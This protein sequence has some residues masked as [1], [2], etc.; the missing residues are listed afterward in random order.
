MKTNEEKLNDE[1]LLPLK[2]RAG[3]RLKRNPSNVSLAN[4]FSSFF[5]IGLIGFGGG[6]AVIAQ[7]RALAVTKKK[8]LTEKEF[9]EGFALAQSL[10]GTNAGNAAT[11]I[12]YRLKGIAGATAAMVGFILPST[13]M[14]IGLAIFYNSFRQLPYADH[15]FQG[16]NAAVTALILITAYR[17][18]QNVLLKRWQ[19]WVATAAALAVIFLQATVIE[20]ILTAGLIGIF[21]NSRLEKRFKRIET[22]RR[23]A[24]ER[25]KLSKKIGKVEGEIEN[26][27]EIEDKKLKGF[28]HRAL[29]IPL[30]AIPFL[31]Q[32]G[33]LFTMAT[34]FLR[35]GAVTF[36]G[37]FVMVPLIESEVVN[38]YHWLSYQEFVDATALGQVT[39]GPVLITATFVGYR[40]AGLVGA[41][42][43][44]ITIFLPAFLLTV[45]ASS[46]LR[47]FHSNQTV[48][49]FL[50]GVTPAVVGLL[51]AAAWGIGKSGIHS[52]VGLV[53]ALV[54]F[55]VLFRF[56]LNAVWI[57]LGAGLIRFIIFLMAG[58]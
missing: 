1:S 48:Q 31:L 35:I 27:I 52:W 18:G 33:L 29:V 45:I 13:L 24:A 42:V 37:G 5:I 40:V 22:I 14:M 9:T 28:T 16:L 10:P 11:Y 25:R 12:G 43:A 8:W 23:L 36:G 6:L 32:I 26:L 20:V 3:R 15:L 55:L 39:P 41:I 46:S 44:T 56:Q 38:N 47:K 19:F 54:C 21:I 34:I 51:V 4:I 58:F 49:S 2:P 57:V 7:I 30:L 17:I 53:L 50:K